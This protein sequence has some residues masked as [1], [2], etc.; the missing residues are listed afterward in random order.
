MKTMRTESEMLNLIIQAAYDDPRIRAAYLEGSRVNPNA[1]KDIFQDYDVVYIVNETRSFIEDKSWIDRFGERLFMQYPED[2]VYSN[3]N[4]EESYGWLM[5]F[6]DGN[7][8]DLHVTRYDKAKRQ[9]E[10][11]KVLVDKEGLFTV[12]EQMNDEI[13][14]IK[15]PTEDEFLCTCNEFWWCLDNVAKGLWRDE[16]PYVLDMLDFN[17]RPMLKRLLEWK[18]GIDYDF[19]ISAGKSCK[20]MKTLLPEYYQRFLNTYVT[21]EKE[22]IWQAV[23]DMCE[24]FDEVAQWIAKQFMFSYDFVEAQN[25]MKYLKDIYRLPADA[26]EIY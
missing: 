14:W 26:K 19:S 5:Q 11:F 3:D 22:A 4:V 2:T 21:A 8:L 17:I 13:Y 9:L 12:K 6:K 23:F 16:L 10:L 24:L 7:R 1:F 15:K 20:Y 18:I 25:C